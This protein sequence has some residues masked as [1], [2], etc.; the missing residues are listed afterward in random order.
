MCIKLMID[1]LSLR[2]SK[3]EI[4]QRLIRHSTDGMA[5]REQDQDKYSSSV[6]KSRERGGCYKGSPQISE[7]WSPAG[8]MVHLSYLKSLF[9]PILRL[10]FS[11]RASREVAQFSSVQSLSRVLLFATP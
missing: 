4:S 5:L 2:L 11:L 1:S 3:G 8:L 7:P 6:D 9:D 10:Y